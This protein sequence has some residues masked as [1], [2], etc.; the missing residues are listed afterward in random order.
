MH[1]LIEWLTHPGNYSRYCGGGG[2]KGETKSAIATEISA[3]IKE[4]GCTIE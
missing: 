1:I 3:V 2:Q 4:A